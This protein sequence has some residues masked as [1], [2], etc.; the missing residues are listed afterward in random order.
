MKLKNIKNKLKKINENI[1]SEKLKNSNLETECLEY[2]ESINE[3]NIKLR[4]TSN[5]LEIANGQIKELKEYNEFTPISKIPSQDIMVPGRNLEDS[6]FLAEDNFSRMLKREDTVNS[7]LVCINTIRNE[8]KILTDFINT[9]LN[10]Q[11]SNIDLCKIILSN[12]KQTENSRVEEKLLQK[13]T[14]YRVYKQRKR[15]KN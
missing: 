4:D 12:H 7:L 1:K 13:I 6:I 3:I 14:R 11:K 10:L 15:R 2:K 9:D 5:A 8:L